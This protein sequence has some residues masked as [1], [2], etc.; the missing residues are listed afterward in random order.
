MLLVN[1]LLNYN[2][3]NI[4]IIDINTNFINFYLFLFKFIVK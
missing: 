3:N 2:L 4:K 1:G